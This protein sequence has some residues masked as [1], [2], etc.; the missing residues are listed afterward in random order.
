M[1]G[2]YIHIPFCHSKCSY[3]D[4]YSG[5][6]SGL[7]KGYVDAL[8]AELKL[9][10]DEITEPFSTV[11]IGGGTPSIMPV[12]DIVKL[13]NHLSDIVDLTYVTE[14][15]VEVN[16]EDVTGSLLDNYRRLGI[17][18]VSIG[19]QSFNDI[20]LKNINRCHSAKQAIDAVA[21]LKKAG[22]NYSMDLMFGLPGQTL[23]MWS[24]D[25]YFLMQLHPPHFSAYLLSY[26]P[27]TR[28]YAMLQSGKVQEA[29]EES[30]SLMQSY[31][32]Q[33]AKENGYSHYEIS[34]YAFCGFHSAHNSAYW[35][36]IPY[37]GLG[38]SAHSFDGTLR[39]FNPANLKLYL[40]AIQQD[41]IPAII[42]EETADERFN[43]HIITGLRTARGLS[44]SGLRK[45]F[46][47]AYV[48]KLLQDAI[49]FLDNGQ[50]ILY[51]DNFSIKE[52][53]WLKSD[54]IM[55]ELLRV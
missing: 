41:S 27:G 53:F 24:R 22:W 11:Y 54:A 4:F 25:V 47:E 36:M 7:S 19:V 48:D 15:T 30:V 35:S 42:E 51:D 28:L 5:L 37:L 50:L 29:S 31:I 12:A 17:N 33:S 44:I 55:R 39:R 43:D 21:L 32:N 52:E 20:L 8:I 26:E 49:P 16:P 46:P 9:R 23:Q 38:A 14:F 3:C 1:A 45:Q 34:N 2:L 18:R 10:R 6:S 13:V 40:N